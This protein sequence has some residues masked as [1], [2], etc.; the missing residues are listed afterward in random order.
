MSQKSNPSISDF[1]KRV[2]WVVLN[3]DPDPSL[4]RFVADVKD[5]HIAFEEAVRATS[6]AIGP[7]EPNDGVPIETFLDGRPEWERLDELVATAAKLSG[8]LADEPLAHVGRG[9]H[10]FRLYAPRML[11]CIA[12]ECAP[13]AKPLLA[14]AMKIRDS[15][16]QGKS[17]PD[18]LRP[19]SKWR[20][21]LKAQDQSDNRFWEVSVLFHLRDGFRSGDLWLAHSRRYGDLKQVLVPMAAA[22]E[23]MARL[24]A[25]RWA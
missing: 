20:R 2:E 19:N 1:R 10:R 16:S 25:A 8:T 12:I 17:D 9:Y 24:T 6:F 11:R 15:K 14:A 13:V 5:V 3:L 18:F 7:Q 23:E 21:H 4:R 22:H